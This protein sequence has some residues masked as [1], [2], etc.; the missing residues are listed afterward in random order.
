MVG[1]GR[2]RERAAGIF[3]FCRSERRG[4]SPRKP[5]NRRDENKANEATKL[6]RPRSS[7]SQDL[8]SLISSFESRSREA[9]TSSAHHYD[10]AWE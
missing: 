9:D 8:V 7:S 1:D 10:R 2:E 3:S 4:G 5:S 6:V